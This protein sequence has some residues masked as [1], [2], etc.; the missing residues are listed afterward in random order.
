M[1]TTPSKCVQEILDCLIYIAVRPSPRLT[2]SIVHQW[3]K[4][5]E[6]TLRDWSSCLS[7]QAQ[8]RNGTRH[9]S[10]CGSW[11]PRHRWHQP[12]QRGRSIPRLVFRSFQAPPLA[13]ESP[14][15]HS[16]CQN[17]IL[18]RRKLLTSVSQAR[19]VCA[20]ALCSH[21]GNRAWARSVGLG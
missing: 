2:P 17:W 15:S 19:R 12:W 4:N 21:S 18:V 7:R 13:Q 14:A 20:A 3:K 11:H 16:P 10:A 9:S 6:R 5:S 8:F 1:E